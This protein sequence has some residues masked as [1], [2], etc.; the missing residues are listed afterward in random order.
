MQKITSSFALPTRCF[1]YLQ[2]VLV[3]LF[4][5]I[6]T[7][8]WAADY[9]SLI[10]QAREQLQN[11]RFTEALATAKEA[12]Q[13]KPKDYKGHY[14]VAM[15][16]MSLGQFDDAEAEVAT[17]LSQAP[18]SA[19]PA[20]EKLAKTI[21]AN[22]KS[23]DATKTNPKSEDQSAS[24]EIFLA[25]KGS[26]ERKIE[27]VNLPTQPVN[28]EAIFKIK[29]R[30]INEWDSQEGLWDA[31]MCSSQP[32]KFLK[33]QA[34][35][36]Y[37]STCDFN[38]SSIVIEQAYDYQ[39]SEDGIINTKNKIIKSKDGWVINRKTGAYDYH[40]YA[41]SGPEKNLSFL[42]SE[43]MKGACKPI[44]DPSRGVGNKF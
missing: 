27:Y 22:S 20:I 29:D 2:L 42:M 7:P 25:C 28:H 13:A 9:A 8:A 15:A 44:A 38:I 43:S 12:V 33:K 6:A 30:S 37:K 31:D 21:K 35:L 36:H 16:Q 41:T 3:C 5:N 40:D 19:K 26:G 14:Y 1:S 10:T 18:K 39:P 32:R 24:K 23:V 11:E 17:A 34:G 4:L